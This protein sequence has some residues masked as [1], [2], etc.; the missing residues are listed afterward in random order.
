MTKHRWQRIEDLFHAALDLEPAKR[1]SF[2]ILECAGD[3]ELEG[4]VLKML[5]ADERGDT[6]IHDAVG[7]AAAAAAEPARAPDRVGAYRL[8]SEIGRGGMGVVYLAE[9]DDDSF[10]RRV[11]IKFLGGAFD[12]PYARDRFAQERRILAGLDHPYIARLLDGGAASDGRPY[13]VLEY[14]EGEPIVEWC[15]K[16]SLGVRERCALFAKVCDAVAYAHE[17]LIVHRDIKPANILVTA[18]GTPKLLDFGIAKLLSPEAGVTVT[19]G[20]FAAMTPEY[21]SPEQIRGEAITTATDVFALGATLHELLTGSPAVKLTTYSP[22]ELVRVICESEPVRG[23]RGIPRDLDNIVTKTLERD[24]KRRYRNATQLAED[25]RRFLEGLPVEARGSSAVYLASKFVRRHWIGAAAAVVVAASLAGAAVVSRY[26]AKEAQRQR[27]AAL[28]ERANAVTQQSR[29]ESAAQQA[30]RN[31]REA[32]RNAQEAAKRTAEAEKRFNQVRQLARRFLFDFHDSIQSL[33][34]ALP[35][36]QMLVKTALEYL[37][38]LVRDKPADPELLREVATAYERV[39]DLQGNPYYPNVGD[40][41]GALA[42]YANALKIRG[43]MPRT[44]PELKAEWAVARTKEGDIRDVAGAKDVAEKIYASAAAECG[45][46]EKSPT[47]LLEAAVKIAVRR[48][49]LALR[50]SHQ[51]QAIEHYRRTLELLVELRRRAPESNVHRDSYVKLQRKLA[52]ALYLG[53]KYEDS[54]AAQK[55]GLEAAEHL[56]KAEPANVG[57]RR[58]ELLLKQQM[59]DTVLKLSVEYPDE[60][61]LGYL[62]SAAVTAEQILAADPN[63]VQAVMDAADNRVRIGNALTHL[64][65]YAEAAPEIESGVALAAKGYAQHPESTAMLFNLV[66]QEVE[67]AELARLADQGERAFEMAAKG[68]THAAEMRKRDPSNRDVLLYYSGANVVIAD[69]LTK[70]GRARQSFAHLEDALKATEPALAKSPNDPWMAST[71][72]D[73]LIARAE[74][75]AAAGNWHASVNDWERA[76]ALGGGE[77]GKAAVEESLGKARQKM[78]DLSKK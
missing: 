43:A 61:S 32:E 50:M 23:R 62:K 54:F 41:K 57:F 49:D 5:A 25:L 33:P 8:V 37:D 65:R 15:V 7:G 72:A 38:S 75:N 47:P 24:P 21:A 44:T 40:Q 35:A 77:R 78:G 51:Q 22:T 18:G 74:A 6:R 66:S 27:S 42:S 9:R 70:T 11:A 16:H 34:G 63:S 26:E 59:A 52:R 69:H 4:E 19:F 67:A 56:T 31:A 17:N 48:G 10:T 13:L 14:V 55:A 53:G 60:L 68:L 2:L 76:L 36:R 28:A 39:G 58:S 29:A 30:E 20:P 3:A 71:V 64:K 73:I 1:Q 12:A 46:D 45:C